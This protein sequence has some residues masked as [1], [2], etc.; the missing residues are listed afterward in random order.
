VPRIV[1][2]I[3]S[4]TEIVDALGQ[5]DQLVGRSH[6]CDYPA[7]VLRLPACTRPRIPVDGSSSEIDR[8]V[9]ESARNSLSIYEVFEELL[10]RLEPTHIITQIQCEVC[11]V[12]LRDVEQ[13]I[14]RGMKGH[15]GIVS[16]QPDSLARI[17]QDIRRVA[18]ALG[19]A[20]RGE[21]V[22]AALQARMRQITASLPPPGAAA[23]RVA[24]IEWV[25]PLMAAGNW[26]PEL[27]AMAGGVNLFGEA[28]Q[29]SPWMNWDQLAA[30]DPDVLLIA[31]CGFTLDRTEQ[32]MYW[33]TGRPGWSDLRAVRNRRVYLADGNRYFNRPGPRVVETLEILVEILYPVPDPQ[34]ATPGRWR[35]YDELVTWR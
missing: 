28:G 7:A 10:E 15:P 11:A 31:P 33:M 13:A 18:G 1:S 19:I 4:A 17:W 2:L 29:H 9:K 20:A 35:R 3:A 14:A 5:F 16:L 23:P 12:S 32:E 21:E 25:E 6:E 27:I 30:A 22:V 24:C 34:P 26:T 8:L